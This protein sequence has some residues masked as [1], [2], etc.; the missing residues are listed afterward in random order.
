MPPSSFQSRYREAFQFREERHL[1]YLI[2][3]AW[4]QSRYR[5]AFQFR[6]KE[7]EDTY[8]AYT[9]QSRYREAFQF[10]LRNPLSWP[11]TFVFQSRYREAFQFRSIQKSCGYTAAVKFQSRYREAFH[12]RSGGT[13]CRDGGAFRFNLVIER[14][15]ISGSSEPGELDSSS[16]FNLVIER[17][18]IS[19]QIRV[20]TA[21]VRFTFQS[22]YR[23]AFHFRF[24]IGG[25]AYTSLS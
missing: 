2:R 20:A 3:H 12:F 9:F 22:R 7:V 4:F 16:S 1:I 5:E 11:A 25:G 24:C 14:L 18:F 19:G 21:F 6:A 15:F 8:E 10:R 13:E 17:L 23:E